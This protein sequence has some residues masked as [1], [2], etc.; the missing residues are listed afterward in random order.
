M[1]FT[2]SKRSKTLTLALIIIGL[3]MVAF[4]VVADHTAHKQ[5]TWAAFYANALFFFFIALGT[6]F[7]YALNHITE[8]AWTVLVKRVYESITTYLPWGA[9]AVLLCLV[10]GSVGLNHI[11][12]WMDGRTLDAADPD[13][14]DAHIELLSPYLN[15]PFFWVRAIVILGSFVYFARWFR[16]HS[17]RMDQE[18]GEALIRSH[19]L[20]YRRSVVFMVLF[21][22]FSSLLAWDWIM[23]IDVHWKS[24]LFGWYVFAGM[25]AGGMISAMLLVLYL[26]GKGYL[27]Q[28]NG[29]HVQDMGKWVFAVSFLW[30][31]LYFAQFLLTWYANIP[32]EATYFKTRIDHHAWLTWGMYFIN[33]ALPMVLLMSRDAKRSPRYLL[34]VCVLIFI[35]H[36]LDTVQQIMPGALG[37][38]FEHIGALEIGFFAVFLGLFIRTV[39]NALSKA[40][41]T[42]VA[43]PFLEESVHHH[44]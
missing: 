18:T 31:Y 15:K 5:Y 19:W 14:Y 21:A 27:P 6:L 1:N 8:T 44:I 35:G 37:P 41:L 34:L 33:F 11:W 16:A 17:L 43:H 12:P 25:W 23:S 10:A 40:P 3:V 36:W 26:K 32:E 24:A 4:G 13:H 28:V 7:F 38:H 9:L 22:F 29:S 2:I 42:V 30:S 20:N 39:M